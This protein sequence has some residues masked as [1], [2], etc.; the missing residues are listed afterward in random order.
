[1]QQ[2]QGS[3]VRVDQE[4][5]T[6]QIAMILG[7][8][9][10]MS[11]CELVRVVS[12]DGDTISVKPLLS[13]I[14]ADGNAVERGLINNVPFVRVQGGKNA[15]IIDPQVGD[16]GMCCFASRDIS[17]VKR[18]KGEATPN[19]KRQYD[20][21]DALYIGGMLNAEPTQ[22]IEF[23]DSGMNIKT[24]GDINING[25]VIKAD[26]TLVFK[27]GVIADSH[28]HTQG[29]DSRGDTEQPTDAPIN[30]G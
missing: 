15:V 17:M 28:I 13:K 9:S 24:T 6:Q 1:M 14:D 30:G 18:A 5:A 16:I 21:S 23:L 8:M 11:T 12:V 2:L 4:S 7:L 10:R 20:I 29:N 27:N 3:F 26:G 19:T 25:L 22:Y